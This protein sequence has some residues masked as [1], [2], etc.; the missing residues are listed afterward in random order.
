MGDFNL[1]ENLK[2][3]T[4]WCPYET[5]N[6]AKRRLSQTYLKVECHLL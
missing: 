2:Y 3:H 6:F 4:D 1:N 5:S